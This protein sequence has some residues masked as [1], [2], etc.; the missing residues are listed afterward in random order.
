MAF[1]GQLWSGRQTPC[2]FAAIALATDLHDGAVVQQSVHRR[3]GHGTG[4]EDVLPLTK[5]LVARH[6]QRSPF[7]AVHH[8]LEEHRGLRLVLAHVAD[9]VNDEK[10]VAIELVQHLQQGSAG[11]KAGGTI[12]SDQA[13]ADP[14]GQVRL[15]HTAGTKQQQVLGPIQPAGV[16]GQLL[17]LTAIEIPDGLPVV[18]RQ[19]LGPGQLRLM[20]QPPQPRLVA[21]LV[22]LLR[23][24]VEVTGWCPTVGLGLLFGRLP[25]AA[26][27]SQFQLFEERWQSRIQ[28][29]AAGGLHPG[30]RH[31]CSGDVQESRVVA[32]PQAPARGAGRSAPAG[33]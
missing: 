23:Q 25:L 27:L 14:R 30:V 7:V 17:D 5:R 33:R 26:E 31:S 28:C 6:Q 12:Q 16:M 1:I 13:A 11:E 21:L 2:P 29:R 8:Q 20:Q 18:V 24:A 9:V 3:H 19:G 15:A 22:F 10:G 32:R 4:R